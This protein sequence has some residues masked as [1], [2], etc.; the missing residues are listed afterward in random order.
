M[1]NTTTLSCSHWSKLLILQDICFRKAFQ[2]YK[3][4]NVP[5]YRFSPE[6]NDYKSQ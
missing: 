1:D 2:I 4:E 5:G 3:N 6:G